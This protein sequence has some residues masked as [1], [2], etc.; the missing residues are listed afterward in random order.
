M[1]EDNREE[2][3]T[4]W[5][6]EGLIM[7]YSNRKRVQNNEPQRGEDQPAV[8]M[9]VLG[10]GFVE[11]CILGVRNFSNSKAG[12][13]QQQSAAVGPLRALESWQNQLNFGSTSAAEVFKLKM[14]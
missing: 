10:A 14:H 4:E 6:K 12:K 8:I 7:K 2:Q 1:G 9:S 11:C 5:S 13:P 3:W